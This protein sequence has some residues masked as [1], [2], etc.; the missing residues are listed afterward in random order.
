MI[1]K[2]K[3]GQRKMVEKQDNEKNKFLSFFQKKTLTGE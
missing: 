3:K 2:L 1:R